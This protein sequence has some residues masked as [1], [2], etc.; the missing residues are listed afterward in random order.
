[1]QISEFNGWDGERDRN[2]PRIEMSCLIESE[3]AASKGGT[4]RLEGKQELMQLSTIFSSFGSS[5][6]GFIIRGLK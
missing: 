4:E 1:M 6:I 2:K 3:E 5:V